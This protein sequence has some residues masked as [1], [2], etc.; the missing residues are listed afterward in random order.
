VIE[1][2]DWLCHRLTIHPCR[3]HT[4]N[5]T[6][7]SSSN[8]TPPKNNHDPP[9]DSLR[10][11]AAST[12]AAIV[13]VCN[14]VVAAALSG[15]EVAVVPEE[16]EPEGDG[17]VVNVASDEALV[18]DASGNDVPSPGN[19]LVGVAVAVISV[20]VGVPVAVDVSVAVPGAV[21]VAMTGVWVA[22]GFTGAGVLVEGGFV[23][24]G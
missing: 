14:S 10:C 2:D 12:G 24:G 8:P 5:S 11:E 1:N 20:A 19:T 22:V 6:T 3:R 16:I 15:A 13:A 17:V 23:V 4:S 7:P 9:P 21:D 18:G